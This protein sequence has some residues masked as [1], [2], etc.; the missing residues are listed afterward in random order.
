MDAS[1]MAALGI[2]G[3]SDLM[4]FGGSGADTA[5]NNMMIAARCVN[6]IIDIIPPAAVLVTDHGECWLAEKGA[7]FI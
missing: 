4:M 6:S 1:T 3:D 7:T 5:V 2:T